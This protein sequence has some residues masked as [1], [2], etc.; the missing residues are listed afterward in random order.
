MGLFD[1]VEVESDVPLPGFPG[2]PAEAE[3]Q[4]KEFDNAMEQYRITG[5]GRLQKEEIET[6]TTPVEERPMY[7]ED[8][9][10]F[11]EDWQEAVGMIDRDHIGW[12]TLDAHGRY[13]K[14]RTSWPPDAPAASDEATF[15]EYVV[16]FVQNRLR[17][18][19]VC[20]RTEADIET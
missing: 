1:Y 19:H 10:G 2:D 3:W 15:F 12:E 9:D 14:I 5:D 8:I 20:P 11:E 18:V 4:T 16:I 13:F 17:A 7:D 6:R